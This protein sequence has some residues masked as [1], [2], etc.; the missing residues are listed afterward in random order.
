MELVNSTELRESDMYT[1]IFNGK[2]YR[3]LNAVDVFTR[4]MDSEEL[5]VDTFNSIQF[6]SI[7]FNSK[8]VSFHVFYGTI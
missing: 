8:S 2:V 6:N 7:Q 5:S 1:I 3:R 4:M